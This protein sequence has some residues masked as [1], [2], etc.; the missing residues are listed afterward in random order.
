MLRIEGEHHIPSS[1]KGEADGTEVVKVDTD[2]VND[3]IPCGEGHELP[4]QAQRDDLAR[5]HFEEEVVEPSCQVI[6]SDRAALEVLPY[7][8]VPG[9]RDRGIVGLVAE[10]QVLGE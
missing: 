2:A 4:S 8:S 5:I 7:P 9:D 3:R 1:G 10:S 6:I